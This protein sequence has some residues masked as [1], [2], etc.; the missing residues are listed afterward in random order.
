MRT[1]L[2]ATILFYGI[3]ASVDT[4]ADIP[5]DTIAAMWLFDT[6][7]VVEDVSGHQNPGIVN[8][9][10]EWIDGK[11]GKAILFD[12]D[13][14]NVAIFEVTGVPAQGAITAVGWIKYDAEN[15]GGVFPE[16]VTITGQPQRDDGG[17][18]IIFIVGKANVGM[19]RGWGLVPNLAAITDGV[20]VGDNTWHHIAT[21]YDPETEESFVYVD[22][23]RK[24]TGEGDYERRA[25][26][27]FLGGRPHEDNTNSPYAGGL[28]E[29]AIFAAALSQEDVV[30]T[31]DGLEEVLLTVSPA[32]KLATTW[33]RLKDR[34]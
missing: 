25:D 16:I 31:M 27:I 9:D 18:Q 7:G 22:G 1:L 24:A 32:G 23:A 19:I 21:G 14:D 4:L 15:P 8:G 2:G 12:G 11:Y 34:S 20:E 17:L 5:A 10:P 28:D 30:R 13:G 29:V 26:H 33:A 6:A 3:F